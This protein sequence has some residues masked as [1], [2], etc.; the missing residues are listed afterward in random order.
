MPNKRTCVATHLMGRVERIRNPTIQLESDMQPDRKRLAIN[1]LIL[2]EPMT[3]NHLRK[4]H[5]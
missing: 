5:Q 1:E 3:K 4:E 2:H